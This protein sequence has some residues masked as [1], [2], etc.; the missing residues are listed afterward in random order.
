MKRYLLIVPIACWMF[1]CQK[2]IPLKTDEIEP[3]IVVNSII[4]TDDTV[5]VSLSES[6]NV[7]YDSTLPAITSATAKFLDG[8]GNVIG[9]FIHEGDGI[10]YYT[11]S[12]PGVGNSYGISVAYGDFDPVSASTRIPV[13][14][15]ISDV[16]TN[17]QGEYL[18]FDI[19][20]TDNAATADYYSI[21]IG[22]QYIYF[23]GFDTIKS[24][25]YYLYS[26]SVIVDNGTDDGSGMKY[27][28]EFYFSDKTF[29]GG[30]V[31]FPATVYVGPWSEDTVRYFVVL[32]SL[33]EEYYK[34][35]LSYDKYNEASG[36]PFAQPVQVYSNVTDGF[37]V[38]G[39]FSEF[40]SDTIVV[41]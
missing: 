6:R 1:S 24:I 13:P 30:N 26:P 32:R 9:D 23:D 4:G 16:D 31:E 17:T 25:A 37:G 12:V 14:V 15:T 5:W 19:D 35:R 3:R 29:N 22:G 28:E 7:L 18:N 36:N 8:S 27:A 2:E 10:Y 20:F 33:S 39:S 38:F 11:G 41:E 21:T 34:Y 40:V